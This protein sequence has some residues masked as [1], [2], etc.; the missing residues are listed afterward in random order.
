MWD[1]QPFANWSHECELGGFLKLK[2]SNTCMN[3]ANL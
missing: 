2:L 3:T 1:K